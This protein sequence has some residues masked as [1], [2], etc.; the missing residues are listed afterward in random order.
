MTTDRKPLPPLRKAIR[1]DWPP[2]QAFRRF[3]AGIATWWPLA[4]HSVGAAQ[5]ES[6]RFEERLG[7]RIVVRLRDGSECVW[8][9][10][11]AWEPPGRVV[12][13][14]HPGRAEDA[15]QTVE[16]RF[17]AS[18]GGT[19]LELTQSGWERLG[20][21]GPRARRAY[22]LG[23]A[24]V[25]RLWADRRSSPV[26]LASELLMLVLRPFQKRIAARVA[27]AEAQAAK[28]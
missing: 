18:G 5:A 16:L 9:T 21:L 24:Y 4:S 23:W 6:V 13:T 20:A 19:R 8:G 14:W 25:L 27:A 7:G 3:T 17:V 15:A 12:F 11:T 1:V 26:V 22:G 28:G 10:V 2:D